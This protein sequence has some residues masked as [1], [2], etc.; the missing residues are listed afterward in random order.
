MKEPIIPIERASE[1][2]IMGLI[3]IGILVITETGLK[4]ADV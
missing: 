4:A 1:N 2:W 3:S